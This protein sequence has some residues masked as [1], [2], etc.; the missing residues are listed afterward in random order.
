MYSNRTVVDTKSRLD[1]YRLSL[2]LQV[3]AQELVDGL[4]QYFELRVYYVE[5]LLPESSNGCFRTAMGISS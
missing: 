2:L 4:Y 1:R 3:L 5:R